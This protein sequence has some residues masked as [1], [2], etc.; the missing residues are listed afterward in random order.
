MAEMKSFKRHMDESRRSSA[1]ASVQRHW[2]EMDSIRDLKDK[3]VTASDINAQ[4]DK[5]AKIYSELS[6]EIRNKIKADKSYQGSSEHRTLLK[7]MNSAMTKEGNLR[8]KANHLK[9]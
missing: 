6:A 4:A 3:G 8:D 7:K 5:H 9:T 1:E 2:K